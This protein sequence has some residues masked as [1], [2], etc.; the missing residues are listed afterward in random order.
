MT[1][2]ARRQRLARARLTWLAEPG[3][4]LLGALLRNREPAEVVNAITAGRLSGRPDASGADHGGGTTA[5]LRL[6]AR[7]VTR[8]LRRW[9]ARSARPAV[10]V[11]PGRLAPAGHPADLPRR[12]GV[13]DAA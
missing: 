8:A 7:A 2:D 10:R 13:A 11:G 5:G 6:D 4:R 9:A 1:A 12:A 3:D